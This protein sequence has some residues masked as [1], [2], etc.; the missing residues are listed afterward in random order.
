M[1]MITD[2][3]WIGSAEDASDHP[4]LQRNQIRAVISI[5]CEP[6][7]CDSI[8][9]YSFPSFLDMPETNLL[10][11]FDETTTII[12]EYIRMD[13][14]VL[15]HC[16]HGQSR[17]SAIIAAYLIISKSLSLQSA[18]DLL[19]E[20]RSSICINPGFLSQLHLLANRLDYWP[21]YSLLASPCT[22]ATDGKRDNV[23][24]I[25]DVLCSSCMR[26]LVSK[27]DI[28]QHRENDEYMRS[29]MDPF[30]V[31]YKSPHPENTYLLSDIQRDNIVIRKVDIFLL[32]I[33]KGCIKYRANIGKKRKRESQQSPLLCPHCRHDCGYFAPSSV[34]LCNNY[35]LGDLLV[36]S[37]SS[38]VIYDVDE[39][40]SIESV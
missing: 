8:N 28:V 14:H 16:V 19:A 9:Y 39:D 31:G 12:E 1:D 10:L 38:T 6:P 34:W 15:V 36:L 11:I 22:Q 30:W 32:Q 35:V 25:G 24:H 26:K 40:A 29:R 5:G 27:E 33:L 17:S 13:M 2:N 23:L 21:E 4:A 3:L 37:T 20:K 18:L 7:R